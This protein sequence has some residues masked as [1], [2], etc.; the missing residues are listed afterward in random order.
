MHIVQR[1]LPL[2]HRAEAVPS[3]LPLVAGE[4]APLVAALFPAPCLDYL[5]APTPRR[6][7]I[8]VVVDVHARAIADRDSAFPMDALARDLA[9]ARA[10]WVATRWLGAHEGALLK[11]LARTGEAPWSPAEYATLRLVTAE[12]AGA[13]TLRALPAIGPDTAAI[14]H[15]LPP[16]LRMVAIARLLRTADDAALLAEAHTAIGWVEPDRTAAAIARWRRAETAERLFA[17]AAEDVVPPA[18]ALALAPE[19][20]TLER[21]ETRKALATAA[22]RF[23]NCLATYAMAAAAGRA[24]L[25]LWEGPPPAAVELARDPVYGWRLAQARGHDNAVL[26]CE[27]RAALRAALAAA[28]VW[29]GRSGDLLAQFLEQRGGG[30]PARPAGVEALDEAFDW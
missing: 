24:A 22:R 18:F 26:D 27:A 12:R 9:Y 30:L 10:D 11:A 7:L 17:M 13:E 2:A 8:H 29:V 6:H 19:I 4:R 15:A 3:Y 28:G 14:V 1:G 25:Y 21:I 20:E 16:E 5:Q 23:Q